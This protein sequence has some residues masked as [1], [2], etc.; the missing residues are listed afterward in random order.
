M[1]RKTLISLI[2]IIIAHTAFAQDYLQIVEL[3]STNGGGATFLS[4]GVG[5][6]KDEAKDNAIKSLYHT[7]FY[8]GVAGVNDGKP[9]ITQDNKQY[10]NTFFNNKATNKASFFLA[11]GKEVTEDGK[12]KKVDGM[13]RG[14]YI[15]SI[16]LKGLINELTTNKVHL[17]KQTYTDIDVND[18]LTKPTITVVPFIDEEM[19]ETYA[20]VL[21]NSN[22][23]RIAVSRVQNGFESRDITTIDF[24]AKQQAE[25]RQQLYESNVAT[26]NDRT[27]LLQSGADVYVTV[28]I[29]KDEQDNGTRIS[30]IMKAYERTSGDVLASK[31]GWTNRFHTTST[32]ILCGYAVQDLLPSFL[33]D[34]CKNFT[35]RISQGSRVVLRFAIDASSSMTMKSPA[36]PHNYSLDNIIRQWV[37]KNA[38]KGKFH[39]QGIMEEEMLFD[40][41][42]IPPKDSDG[43]AMDAAQFAFLLEQY[44]KEENNIS[45]SSRVE[46]NAIFFTIYD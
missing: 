39:L 33:D 42:T 8:V 32:E 41:V 17:P 29:M 26:S 37:R 36:G 19:G 1:L 15:I 38:H 35:Q 46:G 22:D 27:L 24:L 7:L 20:S 18:V 12:V 5:K 31:D 4:A 28:D 45:C 34:I 14:N 43:L 6:N 44:L 13:Y 40:Y 9:L 3:M 30:L 11:R 2:A 23:H 21:K 10:T 25:Q 16:R